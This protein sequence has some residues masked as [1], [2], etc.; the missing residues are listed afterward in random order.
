MLCQV[1]DSRNSR[2]KYKAEKGIQ[3]NLGQLDACSLIVI[4]P[5]TPTLA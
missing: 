1:V 3:C 5:Y 2:Y 4:I